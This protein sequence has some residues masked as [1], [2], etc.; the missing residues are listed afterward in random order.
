MEAMSAEPTVLARIAGPLLA[1]CGQLAGSALMIELVERFGL[2]PSL[3][4][5]DARIPLPRFYDLLEFA[6]AKTDEP[7]LAQHYSSDIEPEALGLIGL[8]AMTAPDLGTLLDRTI[9]YQQ[10]IAE[11]ERISLAERGDRVILRM[12]PWGPTRLAHRIW[13]EAGFVDMIVNGG[14][15][16]AEPFVVHEARFRHARHAGAD[17][18]AELLGCP[19]R[20][21]AEDYAIEFDRAALALPVVGANPAMFEFFDREAARR[22]EP[23]GEHDDLLAALRRAI[24]HALPEG[25]PSLETLAARLH[26]SPRTL[27]RRLHERESSLR[28]LVDDLRSELARKHLAAG[29]AIAEVS[30][31]LG[32]SEPSAFHRAF[33][34]WVGVTP[35][36]WRKSKSAT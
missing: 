12:Q 21:D 29:L 5:P 2:G 18:L 9:R 8:L 6:S 1:V 25:P 26:M 3:A 13:T 15:L 32:F 19:L 10:L 23:L 36:D 35:I 11:G 27:Q 33:R 34:R 4:D 31:L 20:F 14:R 7:K 28:S 16:L 24:E 30:F 17:S 22:S